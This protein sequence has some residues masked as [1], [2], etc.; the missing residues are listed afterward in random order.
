MKKSIF[1]FSFLITLLFVSQTSLA[2]SSGN[3]QQDPAEETVQDS[4]SID[5]AD[6]IFYDAE[7]DTEE[8]QEI[9]KEKN[10]LSWAL[11]LG[12]AAVIIIIVAVI[13]R[14]TKKEE[15]EEK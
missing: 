15:S 7:E 1:L 9:V 3:T 6:P 4:V 2:I 11:Y 5:D 14:R 10:P 13:I 12:G 8:Q